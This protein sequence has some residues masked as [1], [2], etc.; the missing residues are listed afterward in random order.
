MSQVGKGVASLHCL[1]RTGRRRWGRHC[2]NEERCRS[3]PPTSLNCTE[4][5]RAASGC[6]GTS[7]RARP[8]LGS[9]P[10]GSQVRNCPGIT[11]KLAAGAGRPHRRRLSCLHDQLEAKGWLSRIGAVSSPCLSPLAF[12][13]PLPRPGAS[14]CCS[15]LSQSPSHVP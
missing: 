12:V 1:V 6:P 3:L 5:L 4:R 8:D 13:S 2:W 7:L 15:F 9:C 11:S 10:G 14:I